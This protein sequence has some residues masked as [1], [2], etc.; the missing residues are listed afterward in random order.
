MACEQLLFGTAKEMQEEYLAGSFEQV[1]FQ[2]LNS[3]CN[4]VTNQ[5][6]DPARSWRQE[7]A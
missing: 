4:C 1:S 5:Q 3:V 2:E 7:H 6:Q